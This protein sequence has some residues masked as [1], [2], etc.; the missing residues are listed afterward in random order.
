MIGLGEV[1]PKRNNGRRGTEKVGSGG[2]A[3]ERYTLKTNN[4]RRGKEKVGSGGL[5]WER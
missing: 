3:W 2:L 5:A 1:D 4:D